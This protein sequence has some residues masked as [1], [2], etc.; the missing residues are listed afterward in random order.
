MFDYLVRLFSSLV[1]K[2][3]AVQLVVVGEEK[4]YNL[5]FNFMKTISINENLS[6]L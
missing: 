4:M 1:S 6:L 5:L 2:F 3:S